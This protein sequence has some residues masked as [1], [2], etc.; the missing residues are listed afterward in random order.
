M[1]HFW[2]YLISKAFFQSGKVGKSYLTFEWT[3]Q[4]GSGSNEKLNSNLVLQFMCQ[5]DVDNRGDFTADTIRNGDTTKAVPYWKWKKFHGPAIYAKRVAFSDQKGTGR[6]E[7]LLSYDDCYARRRNKGKSKV[8]VDCPGANSCY[9]LQLVQWSLF[10]RG[11][12]WGHV[13]MLLMWFWQ[14]W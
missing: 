12:W 5:P 9:H 4:H 1:L 14:R 6:H 10:D 8:S 3:N 11:Y 13:K 7:S 2:N